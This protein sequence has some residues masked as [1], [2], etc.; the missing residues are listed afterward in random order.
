M[1]FTKKMKRLLLTSAILAIIGVVLCLVGFISAKVGN[2]EL[3]NQKQN[4]NGQ[5]VYTYEFDAE[6]IKKISIDLSYADVNVL[7]GESGRIEVVNYPID[8][9]GIT[10]GA[11]TISLKEKSALS[12]LFS[13][14]FDGFRNYINSVKM[15]NKS[16]EVNIYLPADSG[17]KL[18][19]FKIYSGDVLVSD[20]SAETD[21]TFDINYG[22]VAVDN[23]KSTG[24]MSV[25]VYEG[26]LRMRG[27]KLQKLISE[28]NY[29][30]E[31]ISSSDIT[32]I[33]ANIKT[34]YFKLE[35]AKELFSKVV[36]LSSEDGRVRFGGDIYENGSFSQGM[37]YTGVSGVVQEI[38]EVK[39]SKGN[40]M[41]TE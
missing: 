39:V 30:Y 19:D 13:L 5:Y 1:I 32:E 37:R 9:F 24:D 12:E 6:S 40:V 15:L 41:I 7:R 20:I 35:E 26:N 28:L 36:R 18:L 11:T 8:N 33:N 25:K 21:F 16:R 27:S 34:G 17:I 29:G 10:V 2:E 4:E 3:L 38:I 22:S 23:T 31:W 14:G